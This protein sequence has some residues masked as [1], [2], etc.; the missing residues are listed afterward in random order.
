MAGADLSIV[1]AY[2]VGREISERV[3][4]KQAT[5]AVAPVPL[6]MLRHV[7]DS[8]GPDGSL[9]SDRDYVMNNIEAAVRLLDLAWERQRGIVEGTSG[10]RD[11]DRT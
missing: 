4:M 3:A 9:E 6:V 5:Q 10:S 7:L 8:D 11:L 1:A 2:E